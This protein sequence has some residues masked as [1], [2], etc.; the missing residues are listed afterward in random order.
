MSN[1][2]LNPQLK[3]IAGP[4][5]IDHNNIEEVLEIGKMEVVNH[6]GE[7]KRAIHGTRI[8]G[9]KSRTQLAPTTEW[10]GLDYEVTLRNLA[11]LQSGGTIY[12]LIIPP[13]VILAKQAYDETGALPA[14]EVIIPCVQMPVLARVFKGIPLTV[15]TPAV[16]QLGGQ[17]L[18]I[19]LYAKTNGWTVG[20][21]NGKWLG[22]DQ[23][24]TEQANYQGQTSMEKTWAGLQSWTLG[25]DT[26]LIHRGADLPN[27][28]AYRNLPLHELA[29]RVRQRTK[30]PM[31]YDPSHINGPKMRDQIVAETIRAMQIKV[32]EHT[33]LYNGLLIEVGTAQSDTD[34]HINLLEL[35]ELARELSKFRELEAPFKKEVSRETQ[36]RIRQP[37][38]T[39]R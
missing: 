17:A 1:T 31:Y 16:N 18:E 22:E 37:M 36:E 30:I 19:G 32:D 38:F 6:H 28:G 35:A 21:K 9:L 13:S 25:A 7:V 27:K 15:W 24:L 5:S 12:D 10:V 23:A 26:V 4:C 39:T 11:I 33:Y 8:V 34:Q 14:T 2:M 20:I 3:I 29:K